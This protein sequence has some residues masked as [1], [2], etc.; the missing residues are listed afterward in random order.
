MADE[1]D[2]RSTAPFISVGAT[3]GDAIG[4]DLSRDPTLRRFQRFPRRAGRFRQRNA[5]R[6]DFCM[7]RNESAVEILR[8]RGRTSGK[9]HRLAIDF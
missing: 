5:S 6:W 4:C 8:N 3:T 7:G 2:R 1:T 9:I